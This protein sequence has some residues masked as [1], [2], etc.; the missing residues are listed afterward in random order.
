[1]LYYMY[2][3][4]YLVLSFIYKIGIFYILFSLLLFV[5]ARLKAF[6]FKNKSFLISYLKLC[7]L[8]EFLLEH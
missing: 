3:N 1:M 7:I 6:K 5:I 4:V 2:L 8:L